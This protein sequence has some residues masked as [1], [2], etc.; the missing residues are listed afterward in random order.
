MFCAAKTLVKLCTSTTTT[1]LTSTLASCGSYMLVDI[2]V[3]TAS[4]TC[5]PNE[6]QL[7]TNLETASLNQSPFTLSTPA[8]LSLAFPIILIWAIAFNFKSI[9]RFLNSGSPD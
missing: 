6:L 7:M 5:L 4:T 9:I 3:I 2:P 1:G 8:A